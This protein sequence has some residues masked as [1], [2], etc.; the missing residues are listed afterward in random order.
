MIIKKRLIHV[1]I[2]FICIV[3]MII[4]QTALVMA[5][6][7]TV[8]SGTIVQQATST[9]G[10]YTDNAKITYESYAMENGTYGI[11]A[12]SNGIIDTSVNKT[13][14]SN[15]DG[16]NYNVNIHNGFATFDPSNAKFAGSPTADNDTK[17]VQ[18]PANTAGSTSIEGTNNENEPDI[19]IQDPTD[20]TLGAIATDTTIAGTVAGA[21][22]S[23]NAYNNFKTVK[24]LQNDAL[25][26][27]RNALQKIQSDPSINPISSDK[28]NKTSYINKAEYNAQQVLDSSDLPFK[29]S[30]SPEHT[31][32]KGEPDIAS[33]KVTIKST[34]DYPGEP[35]QQTISISPNQ[36]KEEIDSAWEQLDKSM[37]DG[38]SVKGTNASIPFEEADTANATFMQKAY[39]PGIEDAIDNLGFIDGI[40]SAASDLGLN[41][42]GNILPDAIKNAK[43][44]S[45]IEKA[46]NIADK[47]LFALTMAIDVGEFANQVN[48]SNYEGARETVVKTALDAGICLYGTTL[49]AGGLDLLAS[50]LTAYG[51]DAIGISLG[52]GP[53]LLIAIAATSVLAYNDD[54]IANWITNIPGDIGDLWA[55]LIGNQQNNSTVVYKPVIYL[56]TPHTENVSVKLTGQTILTA[57]EPTY[58][59][60]WN[61]VASPNGKLVSYG[62][63]YNSLFYE[64]VVNEHWQ[65][66]SGWEVSGK[67]F[68][69]W[70]KQTL[71]KYGLN[72]AEIN[73]FI[74]YWQPLMSKSSYWVIAPQSDTLINDATGLEITPKPDSIL[75]LWFTFTP[76]NKPTSIATPLIKPFNRKGFTVVEWGGI[77]ELA[78]LSH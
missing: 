51:L 27:L 22:H 15:Y 12:E 77:P 10:G 21:F 70:A 28:W 69:S 11:I 53:G 17:L 46:F 55:W 23:A 39:G 33:M 72:S 73:D 19:T 29:V 67:N 14:T 56:Y 5:A 63:N 3:G 76:E 26:D 54:A 68:D 31:N 16:V 40:K 36:S 30:Y 9:A 60:G 41:K 6:G 32:I 37:Q 34:A 20:K 13:V 64:D 2:V 62:H 42:I 44:F 43:N 74:D 65:S 71:T 48:N 18:T 1:T 8:T 50:T 47:G 7:E 25:E 57:S 66:T 75:R 4:E 38:L 52:D 24:G 45:T 59:D 58:G 78:G 61:V 49:V 35:I